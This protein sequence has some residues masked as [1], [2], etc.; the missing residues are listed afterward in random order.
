MAAVDS[1]TEDKVK[2]WGLLNTATNFCLSQ[3]QEMYLPFLQR[4]PTVVE[5]TGALKQFYANSINFVKKS[6]GHICSEQFQ[7]LI[8]LT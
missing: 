6:S 5:S 3:T 8:G 2:C 1:L 4:I 7:C